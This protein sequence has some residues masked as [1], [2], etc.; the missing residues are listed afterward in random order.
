MPN[1]FKLYLVIFILLS[2][3]ICRCPVLCLFR[4]CCP[5]LDQSEKAIIIAALTSNCL[6]ESNYQIKDAIELLMLIQWAQFED[7]RSFGRAQFTSYFWEDCLEAVGQGVCR[8]ERKGWKI[9]WKTKNSLFKY[10]RIDNSAGMVVTL[11]LENL[12]I[13][14]VLQMEFFKYRNSSRSIIAFECF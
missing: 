2:V 7:N 3:C 8:R 6:L 1:T 13:A 5:T 10:T 14:M 9:N 11:Y 4:C 12:K